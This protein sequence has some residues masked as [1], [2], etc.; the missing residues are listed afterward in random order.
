MSYFSDREHFND[1]TLTESISINVWNGIAGLVN[2]L[3]TNNNLA[4]DYSLLCP[5]GNGICGFDEHSFY[6]NA[7]SYIPT[8]DFLPDYGKIEPLPFNHFDPLPWEEQISD[9]NQRIEQ[10]KYDVL[11]FVEFVFKHICDVKNDKYHE[12]RNH[13]ELIFLDT[14]IAREKYID[15]VN[16]LFQRNKAAF[17]LCPNGEIQRI[18]D[19][20]LCELIEESI[21][22]QE[23]TLYNL[24]DT[25]KTKIRSPKFEERQIAIEKLW[26][27][28]ERI[29]TVINP[30]N[31]K[32]SAAKL[33]EMIADGS[34][35]MEMVL[36]KERCE[37]DKIGN[38]YFQIRHS[39]MNKQPIE[40]SEHLDYLFFR[41][42]SLVQLL[43][44]KIEI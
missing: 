14:T 3:I 24:L 22:S 31:K 18:I 11:D 16:V 10:F 2:S 17:K 9:R 44:T 21:E 39:E 6:M 28:Y 25:A 37:L 35:N 4:K 29:K 41:M 23:E 12:Y 40:K 15:D 26:D 33:L 19:K 8:I 1:R 43:L 42:Y 7:K 20:Q 30:D 5:D 27:A 38:E 13:Y 32:D 34:T 36:S